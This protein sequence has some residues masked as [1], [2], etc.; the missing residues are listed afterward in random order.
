MSSSSSPRATGSTPFA[1]LLA[2]SASF[3]AA[4]LITAIVAPRAHALT[5]ASLTP[6]ALAGRTL[7]F[8][9]TQGA[10]PFET[11]GTFDVVFGSA[12]TYTMPV[13]SGNASFRSGTYTVSA[14]GGITDIVF[15]GYIVN[16][17]T[18][19]ASIITNASDIRSQFEMFSAG[20]FNKSG[21]VSFGS[22]SAVAGSPVITSATTPAGTG[23]GATVGSP[24]SYQITASPAATSFTNSG[25]SAP[26]AISQ[27]GLVSGTFTAAG[28]F[29]FSFTAT[30]AAGSSPVT[31]I[32][33][34]A[35][36]G[37]GGGGIPVIPAST[38]VTATVG[39]PF[40]YR[41]TSTPAATSYTF[42]SA[43]SNLPPQFTFNGN[44]TPGLVIGTFTTAGRYSFNV[45]GTNASGTSNLAEVIITVSGAVAVAPSITSSAALVGTV[46]VP[47]SYQI[48]ALF[49][50]TSY[51][52]LA[53]PSFLTFNGTSGVLSGT[54]TA[55]GTYAFTV[56]ATNAAGT[57]NRNVTLTVA[58]S[59]T[60]GVAAPYNLSGYRNRTGQT[61]QFTVT[62][63]N[64]GAI[65]GTDVYTDDSSVAAAAVHAGVL[66]IGEIR[67]VTVTILAGQSTYAAS[68]R[69]GI[70]SGGYGAWSGSYAFAG[71]GAVTTVDVATAVPAAAPGFVAAASTLGVGRRLVCP[72]AVRGGGTFSYR[73]YRNGIL[74]PGATANPYIVESATAADSGTYAADVTNALGTARIS[75]GSFDIVAAGAPVFSLQPFNKV[76]APGSVF[77]L[78]A[79]ASG[80]GNTYQWLRNGIS[81]IGEN[82]PILL[83]Q[84][85]NTADAG[86]YAVRVTNADGTLTSSNATVTLDPNASVITSI[87]VRVNA[88]AGQ[89]VTPA[90]SISGTGKKRILLRAVGPTLSDLGFLSAADTM[91]DPRLTVFEGSTAIPG[92]A[93]DNWAAPTAAAFAPVGAFPLT[94]GSRDAA[95]I[96]ELDAAPTG[97]GYTVQVTGTNGSSGI[98]LFEAYD[99]GNVTGASKF[100][101]VS[102]LT[103][104]GLGSSTLILGVNLRGNG[105]RTVLAR[106][107]GQKLADFGVANRLADP[108]LQVFDSLQRPTIFNNDWSGADFVSELVQAAGFIGAFALDN[109]S[110]DSATLALLDPGSYTFQVTGANQGTGNAIIEVYEVP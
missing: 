60:S 15:N 51:R 6:A 99:L 92:L 90:F 100:T 34:I 101:S 75:A 104:A 77:A 103:N 94:A 5:A 54:P 86:T 68:D 45:T 47:F 97:R 35:T 20:P 3:L 11:S 107:I 37:S 87:S 61:F 38:S 27:T 83:R 9:I 41:V 12:T 69:N 105:Q 71:A 7:T 17:A 57:G 78:A 23:L 40:S 91:A 74:I 108:R 18:V 65:W 72:V 21:V 102:V 30:N 10:A 50:P 80:A 52:V 19:T 106:G 4:L 36:A 59:A 85:V 31:T 43:N 73:W 24:F 53:S 81:L 32:T 2:R 48:T 89:I 109:N 79:D 25:G 1:R 33:V 13:A 110:S 70:K 39:S 88:V 64:A 95:L 66:R 93:N 46:G 67:T 96:V 14:A 49:A 63:A 62:G 58:A 84:N 8:T 98:F 55:A 76:V 16:N 44:D 22:G 56:G 82:G 26:I 28:T 42:P 29:T